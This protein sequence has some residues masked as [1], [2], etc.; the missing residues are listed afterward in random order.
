MPSAPKRSRLLGN[1]VHVHIYVRRRLILYPPAARGAALK[2]TQHARLRCTHHA[3]QY[4]RCPHRLTCS[5]TTS[6][7]RL[8]SRP[9]SSSFPQGLYQILGERESSV[10]RDRINQRFDD[11]TLPAFGVIFVGGPRPPGTP[12][13]QRTGPGDLTAMT[14]DGCGSDAIG[15]SSAEKT[16]AQHTGMT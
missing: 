8:L 16:G 4:S 13:S 1:S 15:S 6:R 11:L 10:S 12:P 5:S 2:S 9:L 14:A 7:S 3:S